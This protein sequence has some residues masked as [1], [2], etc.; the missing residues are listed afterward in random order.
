[1]PWVL[2]FLVSGVSSQY[3]AC[4]RGVGRSD[5]QAIY[6]FAGTYATNRIEPQNRETASTLL[7]STT[8]TS[9]TLRALSLACKKKIK[10]PPVL[11]QFFLMQDRSWIPECTS[12]SLCFFSTAKSY[13]WLVLS[14]AKQSI[15]ATISPGPRSHNPCEER[16]AGILSLFASNPSV[17]LH[18]EQCVTCN[19]HVP[20][21]RPDFGFVDSSSTPPWCE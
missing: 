18:P 13:S 1:M 6:S 9:T 14:R 20:A 8:P 12:V 15:L 3:P 7:S 11:C 21:P 4:P 10:K 2:L 5:E 17:G 16:Q 19:L